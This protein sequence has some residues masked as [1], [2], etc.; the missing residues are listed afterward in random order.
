METSER[1]LGPV[2]AFVTPK[3]GTSM[4]VLL[5]EEYT[6]PA[7]ANDSLGFVGQRPGTM[8]TAAKP[9]H[10]PEHAVASC[11]VAHGLLIEGGRERLAVS[12]GWFPFETEVT[13]DKDR[14]TELLSESEALPV[15]R[16]LQLY[17]SS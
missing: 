17:G 2:T 3:G 7:A 15:A 5:R 9:G 11:L 10:I 4:L 16:Y 6:E 8:Q 14:I 1:F 13:T 12:A